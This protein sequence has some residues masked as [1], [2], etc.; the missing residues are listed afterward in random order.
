MNKKKINVRGAGWFDD[1]FND[2]ACSLRSSH[3]Q[4]KFIKMNRN[5]I[6]RF[7][8]LETCSIISGKKGCGNLSRSFN[9]IGELLRRLAQDTVNIVRHIL[10]RA[11]NLQ[12]LLQALIVTD[13]WRHGIFNDWWSH[14]IFKDWW[15]HGT[16]KDCWKHGT[17][18]GCGRYGI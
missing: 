13:C 5:W 4:I 3:I 16:Y 6:C 12:R 9:R 2:I 11:W 15:R 14:G 7:L 18:K 10:L 8:V 17:Y 1:W